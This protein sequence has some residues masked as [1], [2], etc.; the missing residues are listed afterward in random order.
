MIEK[1]L[2]SI[3]TVTRNRAN[4]IHRAIDSIQNQ[5]Y[6]NYEHIILDGASTDDTKSVVQSYHDPRIKYFRFDENISIAD[7]YDFGV[8]QSK[9]KYLT[10]LD[11]DDE[12]LPTKLEKQIELI[13]SLPKE[14][15]MVY[16]WMNYFDNK[17]GKL[18]YT[19]KAELRGDVIAE[20]V[21]KPRISGTPT[22]L[23]RKEI[24][25]N[26][27][28]FQVMSV[29]INSDMLLGAYFCKFTLVDYV[30]ESLVNV[31]VNHGSSRMSEKGYY[32]LQYQKFIEFY[33]NF[34]YVFKDIFDMYPEKK[35]LHLECLVNAYFYTGQYRK[36]WSCYKEL[37]KYS[38]TLKNT[39][40]IPYI[41]S[42]KI[43]GR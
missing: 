19:H 6:T 29:G 31:Y 10:S 5:T 24:L 14:Y 43:I 38:F 15:G 21:D 40:R 20:V 9:G 1:P 11:D 22:F 18:L 12:Y 26:F 16:C 37:L 27:G 33:T 39:L 7:S 2:V 4:L 41:I 36:G 34:L 25:L 13:E 35:K 30:P 23:Y 32:D 8:E 3:I 17:T 42:K 28:G